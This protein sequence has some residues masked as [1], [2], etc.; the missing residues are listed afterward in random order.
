MSQ[1]T[2][3]SI[4]E[5]KDELK[6]LGAQ[7]PD[8][9]KM[10]IDDARTLLTNKINEAKLLNSGSTPPPPPETPTI[11]APVSN[12]DSSVIMQMLADM[13]QQMAAMNAKIADKDKEI[14]RLRAEITHSGGEKMSEKSILQDP[15][16][17][18]AMRAIT[19]KPVND[20]G[21]L[22]MAYINDEDRLPEPVTFFTNKYN[23]RLH[24]VIIGG[25]PIANPL[26][27]DVVRFNN[28]FRFKDERTG[29]L[30]TRGD[31]TTESRSMAE[32]IRRSNKFGVEIFE[33][34][35][36]MAKLS[37]RS[38]WADIRDR[39][40]TM[41]N[42]KLDAEVDAYATNYNIPRGSGHDYH[43]IRKAVAE[44]MAD[45]E[46]NRFKEGLVTRDTHSERSKMLIK[47]HLGG[48]MPVNQ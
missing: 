40:L 29:K 16:F 26:H 33:T 11:K 36:E 38:E 12:S 8:T 3:K 47:E 23:Q 39:Y 4:K 43:L 24:H 35:A 15:A 13:K 20:K 27:L 14:E 42:G 31:Y 37:D 44:R 25:Q 48:L 17:L 19:E 2:T 10:S 32:W 1:E 34:T 30:E 9:S 5:L 46:V 41:L 28:R 18:A 45:E 6:E 21:L 7:V 22:Q